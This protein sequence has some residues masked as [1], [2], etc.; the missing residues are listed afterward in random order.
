[1]AEGH[2]GNLGALRYHDL[3]ALIRL[4][5]SH[6]G[7]RI[8]AVRRDLNGA[9]GFLSDRDRS[10]IAGML[11][12]L[13]DDA[14]AAVA[15][16]LRMA[17]EPVAIGLAERLGG[18]ERASVHAALSAAGVLHADML[19]EAVLVRLG[20]ARVEGD[21]R[22][23]ARDEYVV[24]RARRSDEY[25]NPRVPIE[26]LPRD[27]AES[28]IWSAAAAIRLALALDG[29]TQPMDDVLERAAARAIHAE[30]PYDGA[31]VIEMVRRVAR[32]RDLD[33]AIHEGDV[34]AVAV[35]IADAAQLP[36]AQVRRVLYGTDAVSLAVLGRHLSM[37]RE[38]FAALAQLVGAP[39]E[40]LA[41]FDRTV[42]EEAS[43]VVREWTRS[44]AYR[45]ALD[46][47]G[48]ARLC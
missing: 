44:P 11:R 46:R 29:E 19:I 26:E 39:P 18:V 32:V 28:L 20:E 15:T 1:M 36:L 45:A 24:L 40:A 3:I 10:L 21:G 25:G 43:K 12:R 6:E 38:G 31:V 48:A 16:A 47:I 35:L 4:A 14:I 41:A 37:P 7:E 2:I 9:P 23:F 22:R 34:L 30:A 27:A 8:A 5:A 33:A 42:T 13:A 17:S